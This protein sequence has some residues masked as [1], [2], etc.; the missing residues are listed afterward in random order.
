LKPREDRN[1]LLTHFQNA[2]NADGTP[3][4][5]A[6]IFGE[7]MNVVGAGADTTAISFRA[8]V[9]Y[10]CSNPRVY[11]K[12]QKEIDDAYV[13]GILSEIPQYSE[14]QNLPY[15]QAVIKESLRMFPAGE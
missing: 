2:H 3:I 13:S 14:S 8:I 7:S 10:T 4:S 6:D 11:A 12:F 5:Q 9:R 15:L 1:D